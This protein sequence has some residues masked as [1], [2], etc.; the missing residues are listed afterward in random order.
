M[1][2]GKR[3]R[4]CEILHIWSQH[5]GIEQFWRNLKSLVKLRAM[6]LHGRHGAYGSL[7]VKVMAYL[8]LLSVS[9]ETGVTFH[10]IQLGLS[11]QRD[12]LFQILEHFHQATSNET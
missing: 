11:G 9:L 2:F 5:H 8:L 3:L 6:S 12:L 1:V 4:A 7:G 10:Q